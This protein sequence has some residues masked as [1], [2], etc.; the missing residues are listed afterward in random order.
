MTREALLEALL[1]ERFAPRPRFNPVASVWVR[2]ESIYDDSAVMTARRRRV[3]VEAT[4]RE[5]KTA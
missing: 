5:A 3:L 1:V 4:G 2:E